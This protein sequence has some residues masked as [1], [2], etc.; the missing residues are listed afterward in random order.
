MNTKSI[1]LIGALALT[2]IANAKSYDNVLA[3]P[4]KAGFRSIH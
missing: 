4:A 1:F 3:A 2:G